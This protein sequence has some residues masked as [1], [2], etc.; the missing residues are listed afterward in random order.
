MRSVIIFALFSLVSTSLFARVPNEVWGDAI[1]KCTMAECGKKYMSIDDD[2]LRAQIC[3]KGEYRM[4]IE[5][6]DPERE[7]A[8]IGVDCIT[9]ENIFWISCKVE[10]C[11][12]AVC[13][14]VSL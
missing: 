10:N 14:F 9:D 5:K 6:M 1:V 11:K 12:I 7:Q 8:T 3:P 2:L 13:S 4:K